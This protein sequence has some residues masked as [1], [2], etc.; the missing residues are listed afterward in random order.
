MIPPGHQEARDGVRITRVPM[1]A[2]ANDENEP[3][4][5][6]LKAQHRALWES[7]DYGYFSRFLEGGAIEIVSRLDI[8]P[9][10][11]LLAVGCGAGQ[12]A[13]AAA[14]AG[15]RVTGIDIASNLIAQAR[16]RA[17]A[18]QLDVRFVEGD[19]EALPCGD[20]A[21]DLVVS[22]SGAMF[23]PRPE[24]AAAEMLRACRA[25]G[26]VLMASWTPD[27]IF[28]RTF[29]V[30]ATHAPPRPDVPSPFEWGDPAVARERFG[31]RLEGFRATRR[32]HPLNFPF[33][34]AATVAFLAEYF[35]PTRR[36]FAVAGAAGE[37]ALRADLEQLWTRHNRARDG[38]TSVSCEYLEV[39]GIRAD[40]GKSPIR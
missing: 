6:R 28:G 29:R 33:P 21:F 7:G 10:T 27:G 25:G 32:S 15:A 36:A 37:T 12:V 16:C 34:P 5:R 9:G 18:E 40:D 4:M 23:A 35:G 8:A 2:Q 11:R 38:C 30:M 39:S 13:V 17:E 22:I 1:I 31:A 19:V 20:G 14:Q 26:R 3:E 24:R